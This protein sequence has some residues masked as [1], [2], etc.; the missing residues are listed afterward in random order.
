MT[1]KKE[2]GQVSRIGLWLGWI[3]PFLLV[4]L[5][6][7]IY[8]SLWL[9]LTL[10]GAVINLAWVLFGL[11]AVF[12]VVHF[13]IP[14]RHADWRMNAIYTMIMLLIAAIY[15]VLDYY[16]NWWTTLWF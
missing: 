1:R 3:P 15:I 16:L 11:A 8:L 12:G 13:V 9:L 2:E 4:I 6:L 7:P 14:K 5:L 10:L